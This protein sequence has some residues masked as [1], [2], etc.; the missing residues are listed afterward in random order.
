MAGRR[1]ASDPLAVKRFRLSRA[2]RN[3]LALH[4][5][6]AN[7]RL[8]RWRNFEDEYNV[9]RCGGEARILCTIKCHDPD[10]VSIQRIRDYM[11]VLR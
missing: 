7:R 2:V 9:R 1:K 11:A 10:E 8:P 3:F 6:E 4:S 5:L